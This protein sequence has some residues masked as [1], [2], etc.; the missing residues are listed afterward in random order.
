MEKE[1]GEE[2]EKERRKKRK[3]K[4]GGGGG[5]GRVGVLLS[6]GSYAFSLPFP[7]PSRF[8]VRFTRSPPSQ[9]KSTFPSHARDRSVERVGNARNRIGTFRYG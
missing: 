5:G 7:S 6:P 3:R 4:K 9:R 1:E 2:E 8:Q